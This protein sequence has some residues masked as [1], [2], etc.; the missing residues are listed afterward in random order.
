ME[1]SWSQKWACA[2]DIIF[3]FYWKFMQ[4]LERKNLN[5]IV[6]TEIYVFRQQMDGH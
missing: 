1:I 5:R 3:S 4:I 6:L 2:P